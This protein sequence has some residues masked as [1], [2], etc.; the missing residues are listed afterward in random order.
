MRNQIFVRVIAGA[1]SLFGLGSAITFAEQKPRTYNVDSDDPYSPVQTLEDAKGAKAIIRDPVT[2]ISANDKQEARIQNMSKPKAQFSFE[3][4]QHR[5]G[6]AKI[7]GE[8]KNPRLKF[9]VEALEITRMVDELPQDFTDK[10]IDST[11]ATRY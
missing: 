11:K 6:P 1:L 5:F 8:L 2:E 3:R 10:A 4:Q 7:K 9:R